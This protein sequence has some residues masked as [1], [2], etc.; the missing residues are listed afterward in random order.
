MTIRE[1]KK[2]LLEHRGDRAAF[3]A[4]MDR[5]DAQPQG[6]LHGEVDAEQ[7]RQLLEAHR[8]T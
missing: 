8:H 5:L 6:E 4:F 2:Y 1:L 7:F 3:E